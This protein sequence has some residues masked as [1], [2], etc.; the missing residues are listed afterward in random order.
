MR[1]FLEE[2]DDTH[3]LTMP[4]IITALEGQGIKAERKS[5][6]DDIE[7]LRDYG[8]DILLKKSRPSGYYLASRTFELPEL[9][10]LVDSVQSSKFITSKKSSELISKL[11][12]LTSHYEASKLQR[13]V[14]VLDRVKTMN[15][16]I[17]YNVDKIHEAISANKKIQFQ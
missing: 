7:A 8:M 12:S 4:D 6:Y 13:Q 14:F 10:L 17:Y 1:L 5:I 16:S 15:E 11:E 9:K 2:T 3:A